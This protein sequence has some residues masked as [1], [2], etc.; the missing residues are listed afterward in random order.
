[1]DVESCEKWFGQRGPNL[2]VGKP[3]IRANSGLTLGNCSVQNADKSRHFLSAPNWFGGRSG[4]PRWWHMG[5]L[6]CTCP[7]SGPAEAGL[8]KI[9]RKNSNEK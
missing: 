6:G 7:A 4:L 9:K 8:G 2:V 1:M 3:L 5:M